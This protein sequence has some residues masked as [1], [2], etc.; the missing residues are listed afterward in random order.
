MSLSYFSQI[1]LIDWTACTLLW[2]CCELCL[3]RKRPLEMQIRSSAIAERLCNAHCQ[4]KSCRTATRLYET[5]YLKRLRIA[6]LWRTDGRTDRRTHD[7]SIVCASIMW[8]GK[9]SFTNSF[10]HSFIFDC[11]Y[12][13]TKLASKR[14]SYRFIALRRNYSSLVGNILRVC[15]WDSLRLLSVCCW[16]W[17]FLLLTKQ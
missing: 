2:Q 12:Q 17:Q 5:L 14:R 3:F 9:T 10:I 1:E 4:L 15:L 8:R 11:R 13:I 16:H 7:D 6:G